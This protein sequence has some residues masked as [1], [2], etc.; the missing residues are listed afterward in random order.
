MSEQK[1]QENTQQKNDRIN[2]DQIDKEMLSAFIDAEQSDIETS[3]VIDA[4]LN[5]PEY[6]KHYIRTQL[7]NDH[8]HEQTQHSLLSA[9]L[10]NNIALALVDLPA[11]FSEQA[12][13]LQS[14]R[15]EDISRSSWLQQFVIKS[16]KKSSENRML[17]GLSVAASVMFVTLF[18]LQNFNV[19]SSAQLSR[20][21]N[22]TENVIAS[23][24]QRPS[25]SDQRVLTPT[26]SL[27]QSPYALPAYLVSAGTASLA[28]GLAAVNNDNIKQQY[29]WVEA[30][31]VLS[32]QVREYINAHEKRRSAYDLQAKIR[33]ATY[34]ISE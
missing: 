27:I 21:D 2:K 23:S 28:S 3:Q 26:P 13:S 11:H 9:D 19:E 8:L 20:S 30:D 32:R 16:F 15:T 22:F 17:T 18:T 10:R 29:Q 24:I 12:V 34:Q 33:T 4:L 25:V 31:P 7:I 14:G 5:D 1:Q 6:K